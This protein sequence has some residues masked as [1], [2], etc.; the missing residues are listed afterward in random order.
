MARRERVDREH[1]EAA[2]WGAGL[3]SATIVDHILDLVDAYAKGRSD[4]ARRGGGR[5]HAKKEGHPPYASDAGDPHFAEQGGFIAKMAAELANPKRVRASAA[6]SP[7]GVDVETKSCYTCRADLPITEFYLAGKGAPGTRRHNCKDC[8]RSIRRGRRERIN[9]EYR[10]QAI[11]SAAV[12]LAPD[13]GRREV[14]S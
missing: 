13:A 4:D 12:I 8:E 3:A 1:V 9:A 6:T 14:A 11:R 10:Q 7:I 5:R 2:L